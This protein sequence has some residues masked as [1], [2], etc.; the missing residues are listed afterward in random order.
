MVLQLVGPEV[1][2]ERHLQ[3]QTLGDGVQLV[4]YK[5]GVGDH[6]LNTVCVSIGENGTSSLIFMAVASIRPVI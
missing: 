2:A 6:K 4:M 1:P 5:A 3:S